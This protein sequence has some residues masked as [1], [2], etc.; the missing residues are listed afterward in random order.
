MKLLTN[1]FTAVAIA[2][3]GIIAQPAQPVNASDEVCTEVRGYY[4]CAE[5]GINLDRVFLSGKGDRERFKIQC[6]ARNGWSFESRGTLSD[7]VAKAFVEGYCEG[8]GYTH[9]GPVL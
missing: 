4:V 1:L 2:S 7:S 5:I 9:T 6:H 8:K 3:V